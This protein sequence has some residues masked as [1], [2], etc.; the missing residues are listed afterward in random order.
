MKAYAILDGGGVKGAALAGCLEA[1]KERGIEFVGF[2]GTSAGA[3]VALLASVGYSGDD[4]KGI[5]IEEVDFTDFLDDG[6]IALDRLKQI[7]D[8]FSQAWSKT[9]A[10]WKYRDIL[11]RISND[12]GLYNAAKLQQ[13]LLKKIKERCPALK[14]NNDV[15]FEDLKREKCKPL[16]IIVSDLLTRLP[17][18]YSARG[19]DEFNGSV[20]DAVRASMSYPFVFRPVPLSPQRFQV[21]GG[22]SSNLPVFLFEPERRQDGLPVIAF[23][24]VPTPRTSTAEYDLQQFCGDMLSTAL[25]SGDYL[26]RQ[27]L[28]GVH[29]C[30]V[31]VPPGIDTLDFSISP[32]QRETLYTKGHS[33]ANTFI[34]KTIVQWTQ[35]R[36]TVESL[37]AQY[38]PPELIVPLLH[39]FA[40][41]FENNTPARNVRSSIMLL[42]DRGTRIVAY[43]YGMDG[44]SDSDLELEVDGGCTGKAWTTRSPT[45]AELVEAK[46]TFG[47]KWKMTKEQ[48][49]KVKQDRKAMFSIPIFDW[50]SHEA[51][52]ID[53]LDLIGILSV[54]TDT[55]FRDT[56]WV[57]EKNDFA[58]KTGK[59]WADILARVLR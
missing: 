11:K 8:E 53:E 42:T 15:T 21:D 46:A 55:A 52:T 26:L 32:A 19:G 6:G 13:F 24:L 56:L 25:E 23:D 34:S 43:Q 10:L 36:N 50:E 9:Y 35:A 7:P 59:L 48:Q 2:G 37:Q 47:T 4:L 41:E 44:D 40:K 54:D 39:A 30:Q 3:I 5:M 58:V 22:L 57:T 12:F 16:K 51:R 20:I 49:S 17:R 1:A 14:N 38:A 28:R 33:D 18:V 27:V 45:F 29:Y 31:I